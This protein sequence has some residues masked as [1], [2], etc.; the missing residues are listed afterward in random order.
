MIRQNLPSGQERKDSPA[1]GTKWRPERTWEQLGKAQQL[2]RPYC[3]GVGWG[4][5]WGV[6][7]KSR[8]G[9]QNEGPQLF[10]GGLNFLL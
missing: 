2:E 3:R 4:E 7:W 6:M 5:A 10:N 1:K 8:L 9:P